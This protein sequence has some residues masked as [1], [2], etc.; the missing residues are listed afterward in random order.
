MKDGHWLLLNSRDHSSQQQEDETPSWEMLGSAP[1]QPSR[2]P[3]SSHKTSKQSAESK[4]PAHS[5]AGS[6]KKATKQHNVTYKYCEI[7][8]RI[9]RELEKQKERNTASAGQAIEPRKLSRKFG[10]RTSSRSLVSY[11]VPSNTAPDIKEQQVL[12]TIESSSTVDQRICF[13]KRL[14]ENAVGLHHMS[15]RKRSRNFGKQGSQTD[16]MKSPYQRTYAPEQ[17]RLA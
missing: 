17:V 8:E 1:K 2:S 9:E 11:R 12:E 16:K 13:S 10:S 3:C 5:G 4:S 7:A 14:D 15:A 6:P